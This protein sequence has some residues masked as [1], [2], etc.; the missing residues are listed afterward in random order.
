MRI[1]IDTSVINGLFAQDTPWI[2]EITINFFT[3]SEK[4]HYKFYISDI[5]ADE[6]RRTPDA[7]KR[8]RLLD[9][10]KKYKCIEVTKTQE[11]EKLANKYVS[12]K[13]IPAKYLADAL[14]IAI[15]SRYGIPVLV[16]WNF[17]HIVRHKTRIGVNS[18]NKKCG[19][20]QID[21]CSP[22]EVS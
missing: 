8:K 22:E 19:Y 21:I 11:A 4:A 16:S 2:K 20:I 9:I 17:K 13:I 3:S 10:V 7:A 5:V 14:H 15:A 18:I 1:Y 6:I 12:H